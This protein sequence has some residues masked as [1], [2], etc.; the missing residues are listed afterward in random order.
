MHCGANTSRLLSRE[1]GWKAHSRQKERKDPHRRVSHPLFELLQ[2]RYIS[3][4]H[5][6]GVNHCV[7]A[8]LLP[9]T[10]NHQTARLVHYSANQVG[11]TLAR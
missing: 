8:K 10:P 1:S 11:P 6:E 9:C 3:S 2:P 4:L 7:G 5:A